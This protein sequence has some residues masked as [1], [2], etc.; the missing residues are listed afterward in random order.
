METKEI[1]TK[2]SDKKSVKFDPLFCVKC[3]SLRAI[4]EYKCDTR[5]FLL[6]FDMKYNYNCCVLTTE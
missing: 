1:K 4:N 5:S 3:Y 6:L 2:E